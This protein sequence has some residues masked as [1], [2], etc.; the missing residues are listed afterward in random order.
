M[1]TDQ[2]PVVNSAQLRGEL[3]RLRREGALTQQQVAK[4]LEWSTSKLIRI[5]GGHSYHRIMHA[6][7]DGTEPFATSSDAPTSM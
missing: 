5:E 7:G 3:V 1:T 4:Q 6:L 2:G